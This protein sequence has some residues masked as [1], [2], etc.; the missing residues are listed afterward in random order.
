MTTQQAVELTVTHETFTIERSY[1]ASPDR[2]F[3]AWR[4][5]AIKQQWFAKGEGW[6]VDA[7]ALDFQVGGRERSRFRMKDGPEIRNETVFLDIVAN[8]RI[9]FAY[10]MAW[11]ERPFSASLSTV[12][13]SPSGTGTR[14]IYTEQAAF[15][16]GSDG[17][18][19]R[20]PGWGK[21]F[22]ALARQLDKG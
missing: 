21:L 18:Q 3:E 15:F 19:M 1:R 8:R 6:D 10:T 14:V 17:V 7:Y 12:D 13:I 16:E 20:Q 2:V 11:G 5:P 22:D 9:V 4:D